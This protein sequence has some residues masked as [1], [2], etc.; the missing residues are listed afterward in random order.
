MFRAAAFE[1]QLG[2]LLPWLFWDIMWNIHKEYC[3]GT[4]VLAMLVL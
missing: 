1:S 2:A 3:N 4:Q